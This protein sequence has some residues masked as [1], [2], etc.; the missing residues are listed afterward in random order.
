MINFF[1]KLL[2][3]LQR[4]SFVLITG[5]EAEKTSKIISEILKSSFKIKVM[6]NGD[7]PWALDREEVIVFKAEKIKP[8]LLNELKFFLRRSRNPIL[9][10][11]Y[12]GKVPK[13]KY[14]FSG[15]KKD[16]FCARKIAEI[17]P[18]RG[19]CILNFDDEAVKEIEN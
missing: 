1:K 10:V 2:F 18:A 14:F 3:F 7:L 9:M 13:S 17:M 12:L 4:S 15:R 11:T 19:F 6:S 5:K 16:S 8:K